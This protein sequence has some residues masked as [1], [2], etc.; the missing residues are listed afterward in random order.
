MLAAAVVAVLGVACGGDDGPTPTPDPALQ[1]YFTQLDAIF[2]KA[3]DDSLAAN[4][5]L[6]SDLGDTQ[7]LDTEKAAFDAFLTSTEAIFD[8]AIA[9][10]N[11]L[12][13]PPELKGD[14]DAFV[15]A[16]TSSK[17]LAAQLQSDLAGVTTEQQLQDLLTS[18]D[19]DKQP[20]LDAGD[21][22]C[23]NLQ[24]TAATHGVNIDLACAGDQ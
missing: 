4:D 17:E 12:T 18:F 15:T 5:K 9:S 7:D 3:S 8:T 21:T 19:A 13:V 24:T 10:M 14:H 11:A 22:A 23:A 16:A 2:Q 6:D 1:P 20:L